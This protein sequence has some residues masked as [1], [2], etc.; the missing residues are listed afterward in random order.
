MAVRTVAQLD[1][2]LVMCYFSTRQGG[3]EGLSKGDVDFEPLNQHIP[4]A[5]GQA[6]AGYLGDLSDDDSEVDEEADHNVHITEIHDHAD[7]E[8]TS[9]GTLRFSL[10]ER[11]QVCRDVTSNGLSCSI[12]NST[13]VIDIGGHHESLVVLSCAQHFKDSNYPPP[14]SARLCVSSQDDLDFQPAGAHPLVSLFCSQVEISIVSSSSSPRHVLAFTA[15]IVPRDWSYVVLTLAGLLGYDQLPILPETTGTYATDA[16]VYRLLEP[17]GARLRLRIDGDGGD[18]HRDDAANAALTIPMD[19]PNVAFFRQQERCDVTDRHRTF[20]LPHSMVQHRLAQTDDI[21]LSVRGDGKQW[22]IGYVWVGRQQL[23]A[24]AEG[25]WRAL[26]EDLDAA[27]LCR[28]LQNLVQY[29]VARIDPPLATDPLATSSSRGP[30]S[31]HGSLYQAACDDSSRGSQMGSEAGRRP[32]S[33]QSLAGRRMAAPPSRPMGRAAISDWRDGTTTEFPPFQPPWSEEASVAWP[34][35]AP[36]SPDAAQQGE[37][38][39]RSSRGQRC[40]Q[41]TYKQIL[42]T[43]DGLSF[44]IGDWQTTAGASQASTM[45]MKKKRQEERRLE[46]RVRVEE[47]E[48]LQEEEAGSD[49]R[50]HNRRR[51]SDSR[52]TS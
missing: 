41:R 50:P 46:E 25:D 32:S 16:F 43:Y 48:R 40:S 38:G 39:G 44:Q 15:S 7:L 29:T 22:T 28:V 17:Q 19:L 14:G 21:V 33:S 37:E 6:E 30:A 9:V 52:N 47:A 34:A 35:R 3:F 49:Y 11:R 45:L 36:T 2:L 12:S 24:I 51:V 42:E 5:I 8:R 20:F 10:A 4:G 18:A 23:R 27:R 26:K 13:M 1:E 31:I